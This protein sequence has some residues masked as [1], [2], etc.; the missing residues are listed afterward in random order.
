MNF[1]LQEYH[2]IDFGGW[3]WTGLVYFE[4]F[5]P[6]IGGVNFGQNFGHFFDRS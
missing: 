5:A 4:E 2:T 6:E 3:I 1:S